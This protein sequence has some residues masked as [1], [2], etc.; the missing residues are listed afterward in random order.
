MFKKQ[1]QP[2]LNTKLCLNN[3]EVVTSVDKA[4]RFE[5]PTADTMYF[6]LHCW[7]RSRGVAGPVVCYSDLRVQ[8]RHSSD[9]KALSSLEKSLCF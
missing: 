4:R 5:A 7:H 2:A 6:V 9:H 3:T 1:T 8:R